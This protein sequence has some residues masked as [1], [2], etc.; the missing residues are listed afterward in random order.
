MR[1]QA[2]SQR[3][4]VDTAAV[5][6]VQLVTVLFQMGR[7][8]IVDVAGN[9]DSRR[10]HGK[11]GTH[12]F[13]VLTADI[14]LPALFHNVVAEQMF[15]ILLKTVL[16]PVCFLPKNRRWCFFLTA[17]HTGT[18]NFHLVGFGRNPGP[19]FRFRFLVIFFLGVS[20]VAPITI[21]RT[22]AGI[23]PAITRRICSSSI[24]TSFLFTMNSIFLIVEQ[25]FSGS[26]AFSSRCECKNTTLIT[27][28]H[29][30][31][32]MCI[33]PASRSCIQSPTCPV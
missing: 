32:G 33:R 3:F 5:D 23:S 21:S 9:A 18:G 15:G 26:S 25:F 14:G 6:G 2:E 17:G 27:C 12:P 13:I 20:S 4:Q 30:L 19:I 22:E 11:Q 31:T 28:L 8:D 7:K 16:F 29:Y 1:P 24:L 10:Y